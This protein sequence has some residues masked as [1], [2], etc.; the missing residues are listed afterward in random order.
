MDTKKMEQLFQKIARAL[1][2]IIPEEWD[3]IYLYAEI[4]DGY[5]KVFF[6]YY[7]EG[8]SSAIYS[9]DITNKHNIDKRQFNEREDHLYNC[10]SELYEEFKIQKQEPWTNLT[11]TLDSAGKMKIDYGYDDISQV[12]SVEKQEQWEAKYLSS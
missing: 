6:Y 1:I 10:F 11:F 3:K 12:S 8:S 2:N 5:E 9:L 7:P 4:R